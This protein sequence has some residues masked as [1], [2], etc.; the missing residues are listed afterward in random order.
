M[1]GED[2]LIIGRAVP[3]ER[4]VAPKRVG[5]S[6]RTIDF[7]HTGGGTVKAHQAG[8]TVCPP[9]RTPI[10]IFVTNSPKTNGARTSVTLLGLFT[11]AGV[12][13][14]SPSRLQGRFSRCANT[15]S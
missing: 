13:E 2:L 9:R 6:T 7:T 11:S 1:A 10:S 12:L 8:R 15:G 14:V 4:R 3:P 5:M